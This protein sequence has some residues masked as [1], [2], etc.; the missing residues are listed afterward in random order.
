VR[1]RWKLLLAAIGVAA[2]GVVPAIGSVSASGSGS[3]H[4]P[5]PARVFELYLR[6]PVLVQAGEAVRLPV[7]V[8][9]ATA[10]GAPCSSWVRLGSREGP[11]HQWRLVGAPADPALTFDLAGPAWGAGAPGGSGRIDFFVRAVGPLGRTASLPLQERASPSS[12]YVVA[13]LPMVTAPAIPIGKVRPGTTAL[14]LPWGSG[15]VHAGLEPGRESPTLG[16]SSFD[17]DARGQIYLADALQ[18]RIAVFRGRR[19]VRE[20]HVPVGPRADLAATPSGAVFLMDAQGPNVLVRRIEPSGEPS[21]ALVLGAGIPGQVRANG[22]AGAVDILP[23]DTWF[24]VSS[25]GAGRLTA[26]GFTPGRPVAGGQ[27]LRVVSASSVRLGTL[28]D[29]T[30]KEAVEVRFS[31]RVAEVALAEPDGRGGYWTVVHVWRSHPAPADQYQVV[32]VVDGRIV[33]TFAVGDSR[34]ADTPPLGRFRLGG[35][36]A[37]YQLMTSSHGLRIVRYELGGHS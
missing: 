4:P 7:R 35:D 11:G 2:V 24:P 3:K 25:G 12:F 32:H 30:V 33:G 23:L 19:L 27:L 37:L 13:R 5:E 21:A 28:S 10:A 6:S 14:F 34:F 22:E 15:P 1:T 29:G 17:V 26:S 16:P 31:E 20:V 36:G 8:V 9:C 18:D